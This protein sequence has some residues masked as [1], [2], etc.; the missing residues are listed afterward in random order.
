M[1]LWPLRLGAPAPPLGACQG[2]TSHYEPRHEASF[3]G[4]QPFSVYPLVLAVSENELKEQWSYELM[5]ND[6]RLVDFAL[7]HVDKYIYNMFL[8]CIHL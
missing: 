7:D 6:K 1:F 3:P 4:W 2:N 8:F 5:Q